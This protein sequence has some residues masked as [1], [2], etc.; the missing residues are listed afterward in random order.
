[1]SQSPLSSPDLNHTDAIKSGDTASAVPQKRKAGRKPLYKTA[2]ERRDRNRRAQL[3]F[4][5]RRSDYLAKLEETCRS[6]EKVVMELQESNRTAHDALARERI[7]VKFLE[8]MVRHT[9]N[10]NNLQQKNLSSPNMNAP[11]LFPSPA[12]SS[13]AISIPSEGNATPVMTGQPVRSQ[14]YPQI[15]SLI[16]LEQHFSPSSQSL[17]T[18]QSPP[19][20]LFPENYI[21]GMLPLPLV[22]FAS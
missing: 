18:Q 15:H 22:D 7:K 13:S 21:L 1:M 5:A 19:P 3:A 9:N 12:A 6:L 2:Q 10:T 14:E 17:Q 16:T 8:Q 11:M 4:R 20:F